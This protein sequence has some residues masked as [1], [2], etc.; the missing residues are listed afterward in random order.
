MRRRLG[1]VCGVERRA[2][3]IVHQH[4]KSYG[5][6]VSHHDGHTDSGKITLSGVRCLLLVSDQPLSTLAAIY[7]L[8][9]FLT[10]LCR[11]HQM[12]NT[13]HHVCQCLWQLAI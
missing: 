5:I 6:F 3:G 9:D 13:S 11:C 1:I 2:L 4:N 10:W 12:F 8:I 7:L